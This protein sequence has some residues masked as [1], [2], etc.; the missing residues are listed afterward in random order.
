MGSRQVDNVREDPRSPQNQLLLQPQRRLELGQCAS[1]LFQC[2]L[3][4]ANCR[5]NGNG[6]LVSSLINSLVSSV[7][8]GQLIPM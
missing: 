5:I 4:F 7:Q 1:L 2:G 8:A 3:V 6:K